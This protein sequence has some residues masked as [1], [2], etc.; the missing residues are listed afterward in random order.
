[1]WLFVLFCFFFPTITIPGHICIQQNSCILHW[2]WMRA[3]V[4][5]KG[6]EYGWK[7]SDMISVFRLQVGEF[8]F[9]RKASYEQRFRFKRDKL[10]CNIFTMFADS[11]CNLAA[12]NLCIKPMVTWAECISSEVAAINQSINQSISQFKQIMLLTSILVWTVLRNI[13]TE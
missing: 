3:L 7:R 8:H 1:M 13:G 6:L 12:K 4:K 11:K 9:W 2:P 5:R 10:N